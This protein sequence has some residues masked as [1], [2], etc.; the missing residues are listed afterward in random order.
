VR[1]ND[2][3]G[4]R[5]CSWLYK[6]VIAAGNL[7]KHFYVRILS[8]ASEL[9]C[10]I[11]LWYHLFEVGIIPERGGL[12]DDCVGSDLQLESLWMCLYVYSFLRPFPRRC[13]AFCC[14]FFEA[15]ILPKRGEL[16]PGGFV[17]VNSRIMERFA[18][19][20]LWKPCTCV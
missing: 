10:C 2:T 9:L 7:W 17:A 16:I 5:C 13:I 12:V 19:G 3:R 4:F 14:L 1:G 11:V 15:I 8:P 18:A 6:G 20:N